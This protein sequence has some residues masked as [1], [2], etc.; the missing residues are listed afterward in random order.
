MIPLIV[1]GF[2]SY[3]YCKVKTKMASTC[4]EEEVYPPRE[5]RELRNKFVNPFG[6]ANA[7]NVLEYFL[8]CH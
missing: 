6:A 5:I 4:P 3:F 1:H 8:D 7:V 2:F